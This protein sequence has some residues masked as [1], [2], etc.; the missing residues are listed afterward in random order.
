MIRFDGQAAIVTGAG[1]G[2]GRE[3]ALRLAE[4]GA[5]VVINDPGLDEDG[6]PLAE[7]VAQE[8][9]AEGGAAVAERSAVGSVEAAEAIAAAALE[10]F[11]RIEILINN[12]GISRP[13]VFGEDSD[14]A[15]DLVFAVNLRGPYA[16]MRAVWPAMREAGYGRILN[17]AS[18]AALGSGISG[19]YAPTKAGIIGLTKEAAIGG[20]KHNIQVNAIMPSAHTALLRNHPDLE[21][22]RWVEDVLPARLVAATSLYLVSREAE[23]SGEIFATRGG[24]VQRIAFHESKGLFDRD[25]TPEALRDRIGEV[26][27]A[28]GGTI[29]AS[30]AEH[31]RTIERYLPREAQ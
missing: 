6:R 25:L 5:S 20:R 16:L 3:T 12:A 18:S 31:G 24:L 19:A 7:L 27:A 10:A 28:D 21:F 8:I 14:E 17:T 15:I 29:I 11:G 1:S 4:R 22:R 30:Q 13:A 23:V 2:I 26:M 9:E